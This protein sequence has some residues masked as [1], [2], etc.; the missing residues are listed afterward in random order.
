MEP[1]IIGFSSCKLTLKQCY[2]MLFYSEALAYNAL[3]FSFNYLHFSIFQKYCT[4]GQLDYELIKSLWNLWNLST[5]LTL[6]G[7]SLK[8]WYDQLIQMGQTLKYTGWCSQQ[9]EEQAEVFKFP[10]KSV[11]CKMSW[12]FKSTFG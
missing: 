10:K 1:P 4:F 6:N 5:I 8:F 9:T 3:Q 12:I 2:A 11:N 7:K